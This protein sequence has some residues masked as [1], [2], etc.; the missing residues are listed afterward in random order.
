MTMK[1]ILS[2]PVTTVVLFVLAAALLLGTTIGGARA[3]FSARTENPYQAE[4]ETPEID[5]SLLENNT[6]VEGELLLPNITTLKP[7]TEYSEPLAVQNNGADAYVRV[8][9]YKYWEQEKAKQYGLDSELIELNLLEN[10]WY[11]AP[12][13]TEERTVLYYTSILPHGATAS[14]ADALTISPKIGE[15]M[16]L[17]PDKTVTYAYDEANFQI[18]VKVDAVQTHNADNAIKSSWGITKADAHIN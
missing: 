9:I 17:K 8:T 2:S 4:L 15:K 10:G 1:Q 12:E 5:I 16:Q 18:E 7:G 11:K 14:F 6:V 13:S 3:A